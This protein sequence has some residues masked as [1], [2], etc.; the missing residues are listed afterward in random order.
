MTKTNSFIRSAPLAVSAAALLSSA[1]AFA[2][3]AVVQ[4]PPIVLPPAAEAQA[5]APAI[6]LPDIAEAASQAA[7][8]A[9][10]AVPVDESAAPVV[11]TTRAATASASEPRQTSPRNALPVETS[12]SLPKTSS[13]ETQ[14]A[15][16]VSETPDVA[17]AGSSV[18]GASRVDDGM[19]AGILG[20]MTLAGVVGVAFASSRR[21]RQRAAEG[22][23]YVDPA[24]TS[25]ARDLRRA[26]P[27]MREP[28]IVL[29]PPVTASSHGLAR[30]GDPIVLPSAIPAT[31]EERTALIQ[32]LVDAPPDRANPF[33]T[34]KQRTR[35]ARMIVQSLNRSFANRKPRIDLSEYSNRWPS[36]R[37]WSPAT[38]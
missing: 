23:H 37:G 6:V 18:R 2:Q 5:P 32:T 10:E 21:R 31:V 24:Y 4:D 11:A 28:A 34:R 22:L 9:Q 36:L 19:L 35:R 26:S 13:P 3:D 14:A 29:E 1:A 33:E 30:N 38:A 20:A 15:P 16:P 7:P 27:V 12:Q 17:P 8:P 25:A